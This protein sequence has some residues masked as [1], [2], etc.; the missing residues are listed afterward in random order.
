MIRK[1]ARR[2][3]LGAIIIIALHCSGCLHTPHN[4]HEIEETSNLAVPEYPVDVC[5]VEEAT[6][7]AAAAE[8]YEG[9]C[10]DGPVRIKASH[11][12]LYNPQPHASTIT[13]TASNP[14]G[15]LTQITIYATR[16][17]V[18][19]CSNGDPNT[20]VIPCRKDA[21]VL[22]PTTCSVVAA[23]DPAVC[24]MTIDTTSDDLITYLAVASLTS[25]PE[26]VTSAITYAGGTPTLQVAMPVWWHVDVPV[27]SLDVGRMQVAFFPDKDLVGTI[28]EYA[29][30]LSWIVGG[31]FFAKT[32]QFGRSYTT[33]RHFFDIW[34]FPYAGASSD[35]TECGHEFEGSA[36]TIAALMHGSVILH[37]SGSKDCS[38]ISRDE[39]VG[40]VD[41]SSSKRAWLFVHESS[42]FM[43]GLADEYGPGGQ[44]AES[45]PPN[46]FSTE[47]DCELARSAYGG[48]SFCDHVGWSTDTWRI[49]TLEPETMKKALLTSDFRNTS[50]DAFNNRLAKCMDGSC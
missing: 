19:I 8:D 45:D 15:T 34:A 49:E 3:S 25:G 6:F 24:T 22:P 13:A 11:S 47:S 32:K 40:T 10:S 23:D 33:Y 42:H 30:Y 21:V 46:V 43:F 16:G 26:Q 35:F 17:K 41:T 7:S 29:K 18:T 12:P 36:L 31:S 28:D 27:A 1:I 48:S 5:G 44:V 9:T 39:G 38:S 37:K 14:A 50:D 20:A 2:T 4:G